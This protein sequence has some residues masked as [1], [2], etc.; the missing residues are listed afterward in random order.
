[1]RYDEL[2]K[3]GIKVSEVDMFARGYSGTK[4]YWI[5]DKSIYLHEY[6]TNQMQYT[7]QTSTDFLCSLN[8]FLD[9]S[10]GLWASEEVYSD[11]INYLES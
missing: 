6:H 2:K 5:V 11:V 8:E 3:I 9:T 4:E 7:G 10:P 1:M